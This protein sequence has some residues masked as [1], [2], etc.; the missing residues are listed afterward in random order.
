VFTKQTF[1]LTKIGAT[2]PLG[3]IGEAEDV[4]KAMAFL[5]SDDASWITGLIIHY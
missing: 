2:N 3:R 1:Q 4:A 5:A